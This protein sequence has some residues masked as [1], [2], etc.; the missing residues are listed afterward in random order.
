MEFVS[1][2]GFLNN[3]L[4]PSYQNQVQKSRMKASVAS[5]AFMPIVVPIVVRLMRAR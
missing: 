5:V 4:L 3:W 2:Q 1:S